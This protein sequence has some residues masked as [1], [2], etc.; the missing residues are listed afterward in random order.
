LN[1]SRRLHGSAVPA[2]AI[3]L[4]ALWASGAAAAGKPG[5]SPAPLPATTIAA[6]GGHPFTP[7]VGDWDGTLGGLRASFDLVR[8]PHGRAFGASGYAIRD[9]VYQSPTT[10]PASLADPTLSTFVAYADSPPPFV[11]VGT[12][13]LFPFGTKPLYGSFSSATSATINEGYVT[14][15]TG[16]HARCTGTLRFALA[17]ARR[18]P[19]ADGVWRLTT[20]DGSG[21]TFSVRGAG[22]I[23]YGLPLS[24]LTAHCDSTTTPGSF[25][26]QVALFIHPDG[27][28][29]ETVTGNGA[30]IA[31]NL[32]FVS[33]TTATGEYVASAAGCTSATLQFTAT[34]TSA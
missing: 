9:L 32:R 15:G 25:T 10:C 33:A 12:N 18:V 31:L 14:T 20:Q 17:P 7:T 8:Y 2:I 5:R 1:H 29:T 34:R 23:A 26:G 13:G 3:A 30:K 28:G 21:G 19:A 24:N 27:T 4:A 11:L 6:H 16:A 22:R